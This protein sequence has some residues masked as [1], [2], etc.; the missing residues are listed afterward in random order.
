MA[1]KN[2][3]LPNVFVQ[4]IFVVCYFTVW[5]WYLC[6]WQVLSSNE[7]RSGFFSLGCCIQIRQE[8]SLC[9]ANTVGFSGAVQTISQELVGLICRVFF[10]LFYGTLCYLE[11]HALNWKVCVWLCME[12]WTQ[13]VFSR[14][15]FVS[16]GMSLQPRWHAFDPV[17]SGS[18]RQFMERWLCTWEGRKV[19]GW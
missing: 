16:R 7:W 10:L 15:I 6:K 9:C 13:K 19:K 8:R 4:K 11:Y 2:V 18:R 5:S 17:T 1:I 3:I 12:G 14:G